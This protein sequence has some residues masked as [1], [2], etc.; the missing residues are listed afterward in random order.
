MKGG[1]GGFSLDP[2]GEGRGRG[3][4]NER[5]SERESG[6][7]LSS[8]EDWMEMDGNST[9][10]IFSDDA[11]RVFVFLSFSL[12]IFSLSHSS[13]SRENEIPFFLPLSSS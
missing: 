4:G 7:N 12:F 6:K 8:V 9:F 5:E 10:F 3:R 2:G 1:G 13:L 11:I